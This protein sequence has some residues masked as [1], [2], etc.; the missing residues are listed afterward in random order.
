MKKKFSSK[1]KSSK[2]ARKQRKYRHN[3][4]LHIKQKFVSVHLS[5][6]LRKKYNKRNLGVKK[7]DKVKVVRGQFRKHTGSVES[8]D[9]KKSKVR[10]SGIEI[11]KKEGTKT[12]YPIDPS[13]LI[14][15]ELS[16]DDK[17]RQKI[18]ERVKK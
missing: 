3:A 10:V 5:K 12:T 16:I 2:Q 18:V 8:V 15:T 14:I 7:G 17:R 11:T 4:S 9:L 13:N 1:W 6:E